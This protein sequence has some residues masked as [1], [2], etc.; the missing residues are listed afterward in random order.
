MQ[1]CSQYFPS[2]RPCLSPGAEQRAWQCSQSPSAPCWGSHNA[3]PSLMEQQ[4]DHPAALLPFATPKEIHSCSGR[5][6]LYPA[7]LI[8]S[9]QGFTLNIAALPLNIAAFTLNIGAFTLNIGAFTL[10]IGACCSNL[11]GVSGS[12]TVSIKQHE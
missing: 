9:C 1:R 10:N 11:Q 7:L 5:L 4:W 8:W 3:F 6:L 2:C 12:K